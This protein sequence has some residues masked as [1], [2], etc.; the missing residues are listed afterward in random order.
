MLVPKVSPFL[1]STRCTNS[2]ND[3]ISSLLLLNDIVT[4]NPNFSGPAA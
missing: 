2:F 1:N 4:P 3:P